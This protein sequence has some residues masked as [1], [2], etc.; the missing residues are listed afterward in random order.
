MAPW[1][2]P[3]YGPRKPNQRDEPGEH[4]RLARETSAADKTSMAY[5]ADTIDRHGRPIRPARRTER[6]G[7]GD[8]TGGPTGQAD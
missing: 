2:D 7:R 6:D 5:H 3:L 8:Q 4:G 1:F